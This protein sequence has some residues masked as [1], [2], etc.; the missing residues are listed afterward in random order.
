LCG[1]FT[2]DV[3]GACAIKAMNRE[4]L[5]LFIEHGRLVSIDRLQ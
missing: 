5:P 4:M 1:V 2:V 3:P